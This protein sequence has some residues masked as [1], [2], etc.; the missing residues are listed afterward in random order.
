[1]KA[2]LFALA[3]VPLLAAADFPTELKKFDALLAKNPGRGIL[4]HVERLSGNR[5][6]VNIQGRSLSFTHIQAHGESE[7]HAKQVFSYEQGFAVDAF[8]TET[9]VDARHT[10]LSLRLRGLSGEYA[11]RVACPAQPAGTETAHFIVPTAS[12]AQTPDKKDPK[13]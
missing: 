4:V 11:L 1:M 8:N 2:L 6:R 7:E 12:N 5:L 13:K 10:V 3:L 9:V